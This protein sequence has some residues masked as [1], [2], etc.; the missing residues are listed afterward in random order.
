VTHVIAAKEIENL[1][2]ESQALNSIRQSMGSDDFARKV[3]EKVYKDDIDR[4][5]SMEDMWKTRQP[6]VP[7][8]YDELSEA[9]EGISTSIAQ[10]DQTTW[11]EAENFAVFCDR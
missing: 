7:L 4:L 8:N 1:R 9:A 5:R 11:T 10:Q 3:F 2:K 6:P